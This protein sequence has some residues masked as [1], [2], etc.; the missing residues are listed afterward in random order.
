MKFADKFKLQP[1]SPRAARN[2][3]W[4]CVISSF[5]LAVHAWFYPQTAPATGRRAWFFNLLFDLF[6]VLGKPLFFL[7]L[8]FYLLYLFLSRNHAGKP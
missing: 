7:L 3:M 1:V 8:G 4:F 6:G 2:L 5:S